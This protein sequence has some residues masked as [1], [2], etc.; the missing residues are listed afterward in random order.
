MD[1]KRMD[2]ENGSRKAWEIV[3]VTGHL[4]SS[5]A[6]DF[7]VYCTALVDKGVT[8]IALDLAGIKYLSSAGLRCVIKLQK[9][10]KAGGGRMALCAPSE[11]AVMVLRLAGLLDHLEI[12]DS[13][14]DLP[15]C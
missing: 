14:D 10:L 7:D 9:A 1:E 13:R 8:R 6:A 11:P 2:I 12:F 4:D 15:E 5:S 3:T